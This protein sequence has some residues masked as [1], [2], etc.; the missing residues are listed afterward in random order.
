MFRWISTA[1]AATLVFAAL[2]GCM[3]DSDT[4]A[5]TLHLINENGF[6]WQL[7]SETGT[8]QVVTTISGFPVGLEPL[9]DNR[10]LTLLTDSGCLGFVSHATLQFTC[11]WTSS[12][13]DN[14][15]GMARVDD[16]LV[17]ILSSD[18]SLDL[19]DFREK[20]LLIPGTTG[21][22]YPEALCGIPETVT[23]P[24]GRLLTT[25][26]ALLVSSPVA[27]HVQLYLVEISLNQETITT[28][29]LG[30]IPTIQSITVDPRDNILVGYNEEYH[31][32]YRIN[33]ET[34]DFSCDT[35]SADPGQV[36][37]MAIF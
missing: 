8:P 25:E 36:T 10:I 29:Y 5:P 16:Y 15:I 17:I 20:Y 31:C 9:P 11:D 7:N 32:L 37:G 6:L 4:A 18:R 21:M 22:A 30:D 27:N 28:S 24:D 13:W 14:A 2:Q 3:N 19:Y 1:M 33:P 23:G 34:L 26:D 35:L 12:L